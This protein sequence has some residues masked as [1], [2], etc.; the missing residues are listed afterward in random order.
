MLTGD[1]LAKLKIKRT[2]FHDVPNRPKMLE[3]KVVLA[4]LETKVDGGKAKILYDRITQVLGSKHAYSMRFSASPATKVPDEV[5]A[6][7]SKE[8]TSEQFVA[9]SRELANYLFAQHTGA[10]SPGLLCVME[11]RV[12]PKQIGR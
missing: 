8:H 2:I 3:T 1:D 6:F 5:R 4:D 9:M 12:G 7:T 10:T 11:V